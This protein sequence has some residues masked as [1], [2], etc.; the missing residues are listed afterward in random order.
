MPRLAVIGFPVSHSRSPAMQTAALEQLGLAPEWSYGAVEATPEG[1]AAAVRE[2]ASGDYAGANVTVPHKEAALALSEER[3]E[4]AEQI[5]AANTLVFEAGRIEAHNTDADGLLAA[6]PGSP[7]D[8]RAL[9]LGA[10]GAARAAV[11]A[12]L[13]EGAEVEVWNRTAE[14]AAALCA[15]LGGAAVTEPRQ[16]GYEL[17]VNTSAAGLRGEDPF[18]H[19]PLERDLF[20]PSQTVVDL[21]YGEAPSRLLD[22]AIGAGATTVDG[23]EILVQQGARSLEIWTKREPNLDAM[24][25]AARP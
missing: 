13:W 1:F 9:V 21:V 3:S 19:L 20:A 17:I 10:G 11:W 23:L 24:R 12:L 2:M 14:K 15:Q 8:Q 7:R 4:A 25:A 16:E 18:E 5:G 6:L 22:A